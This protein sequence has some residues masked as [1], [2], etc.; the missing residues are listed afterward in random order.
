V[1]RAIVQRLAARDPKHQYPLA[2]VVITVVGMDNYNL[3]VTFHP[4]QVGLAEAEVRKRIEDEKSMVEYIDRS[5]VEGVFCIKVDGDPKRMVTSLRDDFSENPGMLAHTYHW[6]PIDRWVP[7]N[8]EDMIEAVRETARGI[9]DHESW[10]MH[11]HK[12]HHEKHSEELV[13]ALTDPIRK[14]KVDL[15]NPDKIIAV[16]VLGN[17]AGISLLERDQ[18][19]DVN[20][21][22]QEIGL[23]RII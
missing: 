23:T 13:L 12:R 8:D 16:E 6:V 18:I 20:K 21:M 3:L 1:H 17:M 2:D 11:M 14:G 7:A 9:G 22:R 19:I 5:S 4:N 10:M 15:K